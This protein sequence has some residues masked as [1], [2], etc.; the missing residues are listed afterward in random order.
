MDTEDCA[1]CRARGLRINTRL[2]FFE[3]NQECV[4][5]TSQIAV[6]LDCHYLSSLCAAVCRRLNLFVQKDGNLSAVPSKLVQVSSSVNMLLKSSLW[7]F[8]QSS[9]LHLAI[10]GIVGSAF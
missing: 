1:S 6:G 3:A 2:E 9:C 7:V 10:Y 4:F 5:Y 8:V